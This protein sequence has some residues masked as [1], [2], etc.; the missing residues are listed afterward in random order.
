MKRL[1]SLLIVLILLSGCSTLPKQK[2]ESLSEIRTALR[3]VV[4]TASE[5][6]EATMHSQMTLG[7]LIPPSSS[8]LL[9]QKQIPRLEEHLL[10][11]SKQVITAFRG[12]TIAMP[13]LLKPYIEKLTIEDPRS[14]MV[15][16]DSSATAL[17]LASYAE[18]IEEDVRSMLQGYLLD[19]GETWDM[20]ADRY[21]IWSRSKVLLGEESLPALDSDPTDHL[22]QTFLSTYLDQLTNEELYLRTTPV[23][24]GTGSFYEILNN[25]VQP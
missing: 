21:A 10:L 12:A 16:N 18:D 3:E 15:Q 11:W 13:G 7:T 6:I 8:S 22:I 25:K 9:D 20:L 1:L 24:Q 14:V 23:F 19:S 2:E 4:Q 5:R 17:L